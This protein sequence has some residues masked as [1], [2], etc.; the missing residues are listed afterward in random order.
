MHDLFQELAIY[1][2]VKSRCVWS[3]FLE[4]RF[5]D[6]FQCYSVIDLC[7]YSVSQEKTAIIIS[8]DFN[9]GQRLAHYY[10]NNFLLSP[11]SFHVWANANSLITP[12]SFYFYKFVID[13]GQ[14]YIRGLPWQDEWLCTVR[15]YLAVWH[16]DKMTYR[17]DDIPTRRA[18]D[19][20]HDR[21]T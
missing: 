21:R 14:F 19:Y 2:L 3:L 17:Q 10:C 1:Q 15:C 4:F 5:R 18:D 7:T 20:Q 12:L 9:L 6:R 16:A 13:V 8:R 11:H